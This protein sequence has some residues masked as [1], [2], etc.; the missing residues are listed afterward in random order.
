MICVFCFHRIIVSTSISFGLFAIELIGFLWVLSMTNNWVNLLCILSHSITISYG[1][2]ES[3]RLIAIATPVVKNLDSY[4]R[5]QL[6]VLSGIVSDSFIEKLSYSSLTVHGQFIKKHI[7]ESWAFR[8]SWVQTVKYSL[9]I[10]EEAL[11]KCTLWLKVTWC[12]NMTSQLYLANMLTS[13]AT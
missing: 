8:A 6:P 2:N 13:I 12:E 4:L 9:H 1:M 5:V 11:T 7:T 3:W 10:S